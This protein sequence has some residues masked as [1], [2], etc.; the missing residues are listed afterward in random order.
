[1]RGLVPV[2]SHDFLAASLDVERSYSM[3]RPA[4]EVRSEHLAGLELDPR[5]GGPPTGSG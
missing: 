1:M 4:G 3:L 2:H 5:Q